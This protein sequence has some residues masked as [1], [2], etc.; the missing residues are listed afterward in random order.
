MFVTND[1]REFVA[2]AH[3]VFMEKA[4]CRLLFFWNLLKATTLK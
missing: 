2:L 3:E 1:K 4:Y